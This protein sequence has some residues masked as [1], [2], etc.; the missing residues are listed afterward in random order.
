MLQRLQGQDSR[1]TDDPIEASAP[2]NPFNDPPAADNP[3][4]PADVDN[5]PA[6]TTATPSVAYESVAYESAA[7]PAA[8]PAVA[9]EQV[10]NP[11]SQP[12]GQ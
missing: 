7:P 11:A 6:T 1:L 4:Q 12:A 3:Y 9:Y 2:D 5:E 8:P 10:P